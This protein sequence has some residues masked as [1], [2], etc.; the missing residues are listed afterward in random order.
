M[1]YIGFYGR[2]PKCQKKNGYRHC[3]YWQMNTVK[4]WSA[5]IWEILKN[6]NFLKAVPTF[7]LVEQGIICQSTNM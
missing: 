2:T 7:C 3:H 6:V 5:E 1:V 4:R